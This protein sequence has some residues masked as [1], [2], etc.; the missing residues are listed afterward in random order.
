MSGHKG[1]KIGSLVLLA[2]AVVGSVM[3]LPDIARYVRIHT[4]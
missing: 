3:M 1:L 4:M 2:L